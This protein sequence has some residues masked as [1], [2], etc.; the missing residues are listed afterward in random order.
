[1][2]YSLGQYILVGLVSA[3]IVA[4]IVSAFSR[5]WAD[6]FIPVAILGGVIAIVFWA[7]T[8]I[9]P[10]LSIITETSGDC[11][12]VKADVKSNKKVNLYCEK[13]MCGTGHC[14]LVS[15]PKDATDDSQK[16][17]HGH[18]PES[19]PYETTPEEVEARRWKCEC[20]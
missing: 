13:S 16:V 10:L 1:M 11:G 14:H 4:D 2:R 17:D 20:K 15:W 8:T 7:S 18:S 5:G 3:L 9:P 12:N 6:A 19:E